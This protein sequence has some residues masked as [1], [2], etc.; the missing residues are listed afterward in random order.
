MKITP[1]I[2]IVFLILGSMLSG[3]CDKNDED[4]ANLATIEISLHAADAGIVADIEY[5]SG[6]GPIRL[7]DEPL[8]WSIEYNAIF[9]IGDE[10]SFKAESG[11]QSQ[12][13]ARI[14]VDDQVV[15]SGSGTHLLQISYI[16]GLK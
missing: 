16:K 14:T 3:A 4:P 9:N 5:T 12:M 15:A 2:L 13:S 7:E 8:P 1:A 6:F 11:A 10:L